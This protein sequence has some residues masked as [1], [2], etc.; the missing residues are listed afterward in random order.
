MNLK[1]ETIVQMFRKIIQ[2]N[3]VIIL[4]STKEC[5]RKIISKSGLKLDLNPAILGE[6]LNERLVFLNDKYDDCSSG[7]ESGSRMDN[8]RLWSALNPLITRFTTIDQKTRIISNCNLWL[9]Q[10]ESF[11]LQALLEICISRFFTWDEETRSLTGTRC[12][13]AFLPHPTGTLYFM[14]TSK[15]SVFTEFVLLL[16]FVF[17]FK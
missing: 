16:F 11:W 8:D 5:Y 9:L 13:L 2:L 10:I 6:S 3:A 12:N 4:K 1:F 15:G 14:Q 17:V 7:L